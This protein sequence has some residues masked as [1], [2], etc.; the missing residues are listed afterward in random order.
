MNKKILITLCIIVWS[1]YA[2]GNANIVLNF[3]DLNIQSF[4]NKFS[5][6][7][8]MTPGNNFW[9]SIFWLAS[10]SIPETTITLSGTT[11]TCTK[12]IKWLYF[13]SQRGKRLRPLD[14]ETLTSLQQ[15]NHSYDDLQITWWL[16]T[17]CDSTDPYSIF[18]AITYIRKG[19]TWYLVAGTKLNYQQNKIEPQF[20]KSLQYFDNK[21]I[22]GYIYDSNWGIGY[23]G[24]NLTGH[25]RLISFLNNGGSINN[26]FTYSIDTIISSHPTERTTSII[27][28]W[29]NAMETMRNIIIQGSVGLSKSMDVTE[30][31]SLL[32]NLQNQT[33]IYNA[34]NI[35]SS[36]LINLGKQKA[37]ELCQGKEKYTPNFTKIL[38]AYSESIICIENTD[39][40]INLDIPSTYEN[41]TI[42]VK[43][44]N[45][46]LQ[47]GMKENDPPLDL[48]ID[49]G[50]LYLPETIT[51]Q[52]FNDQW[53][54]SETNP[55]T[56]GLYLK[57][58]LIINGL[59][60]W[61]ITWFNH[62]LHFQGKITTLN[63]PLEP[64][65]ER[66]SQITEMLGYG[67]ENFISLQKI[68]TRTCGFNWI[69][70]DNT[71]C[72]T[73]GIISIT[74][75]VILNGNYPSNLLQ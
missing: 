15:Q 13:N 75:L 53:F 2:I 1:I 5:L 71:P 73:G 49:K 69:G 54:A 26:A 21:I 12:Q 51:R 25:E 47:G 48:F 19:T 8:F 34:S 32:G 46:I 18:G 20:A 10:K 39:V 35:N 38:W 29:N 4:G 44:G 64:T 22:I 61:S 16:Y 27:A 24:G 33:L 37:Q 70:S 40:K 28:S 11:K 23:I 30:R 66:I 63:T 43:S 72:G 9:W 67:H 50:I 68:F 42:I 52:S 56:S 62:K 36:T 55:I 58:N 45:V 17:T 41:K 74:P 6:V 14:S 59:I 60:L 7:H 3:P 65:T 57:G 31:F